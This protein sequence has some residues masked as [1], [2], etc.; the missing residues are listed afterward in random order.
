METF[1]KCKKCGRDLPLEN[2][3]P[4]INTEDG[5]G[6]G[7]KECN[8]EHYQRQKEKI[9]KCSILE[10]DWAFKSDKEVKYKEKRIKYS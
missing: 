4:S 8:T 10:M 2:F 7:C 3:K 6:K 5:Y 1:K 9:A